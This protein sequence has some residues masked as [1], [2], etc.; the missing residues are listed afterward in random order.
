[1]ER[2]LSAGLIETPKTGQGRT[3]DM[4][5]QLTRTRRRLEIDRMVETLRGGCTEVPP[6]VFCT[7]VDTP[8]DESRVRRAFAQAPERVQLPAFRLYDLRHTFASL[9]LAKGEP[10]TYVS[11]QLGHA[12]ATTIL[13]WCARW[14]PRTDKR[15][16][17][18]LDDPQADAISALGVAQAG[19]V[20]SQLVAKTGSGDQ[21][22]T[23]VYPKLPIYFG[24]PSRTR[25]LDPLIKSPNQQPP[26]GS[27]DDVSA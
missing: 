6:C 7:E 9:L 11:A 24:G 14:L 23:P 22:A 2:A 3:V 27:D 19:T 17:D 15:A 8:L 13:R 1:V 4:S 26:A 16:V 20:C 5:E 21:T 12:D 25:T 18:R 10:I